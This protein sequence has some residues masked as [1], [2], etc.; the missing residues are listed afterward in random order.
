VKYTDILTIVLAAGSLMG[1]AYADEALAKAKACLACHAVDKK[2]VGPAFKDI[3][4]KYKGQA[5]ASAMLMEKVQ[6]GGK[7]AWGT[8]PMPPNKLSNDEAQTLVMWVL[9]RD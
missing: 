4:A 7:G 2:V 1:N 3:A 6:K 8:I 5:D 9:S